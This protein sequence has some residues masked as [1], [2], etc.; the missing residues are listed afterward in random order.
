[1]TVT[2]EVATFDFAASRTVRMAEMHAIKRAYRVYLV[3]QL[4]GSVRMSHVSKIGT[5]AVI[6]VAQLTSQN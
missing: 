1:M 6:T 2:I 3:K 5:F 4:S